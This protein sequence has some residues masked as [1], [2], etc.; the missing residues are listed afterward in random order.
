[1]RQ[2][3]RRARHLEAAALGDR[4][5]GDVLEDGRR[6]TAASVVDDIDFGITHVLRGNDHRPTSR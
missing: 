1:M 6:R 2:S 3:E 4:F 5:E